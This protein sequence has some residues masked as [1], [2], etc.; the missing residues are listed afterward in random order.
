MHTDRRCVNV[1]C[2]KSTVNKKERPEKKEHRMDVNIGS[3]HNYNT[4]L[5]KQIEEKR[6]SKNELFFFFLKESL[7][8]WFAFK[9]VTLFY[10]RTLDWFI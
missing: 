7:C 4:K 8:H 5:F 6:F 9:G 10:S 3:H 1:K 2:K